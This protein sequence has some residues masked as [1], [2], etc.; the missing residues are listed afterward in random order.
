[1]NLSDKARPQHRAP[2]RCRRE[3]NWG[4]SKRGEW[5][6]G[7]RGEEE[8]GKKTSANGCHRE[9]GHRSR[10]A[11]NRLRRGKC[12]YCL[13]Q[14]FPVQGNPRLAFGNRP[15]SE[16]RSGSAQLVEQSQKETFSSCDPSRRPRV[17]GFLFLHQSARIAIASFCVFQMCGA[18][19]ELH[20]AFL[21]L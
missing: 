20:S 13:L 15:Q 1:M 12:T 8:G 18:K 16:Q 11:P 14:Q 19:F 3:K 4:V 7:K 5:G 21:L 9:G 2:D 10:S 17:C 6:V